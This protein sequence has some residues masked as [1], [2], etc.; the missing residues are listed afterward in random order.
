MVPILRKTCKCIIEP[1][2]LR[3]MKSSPLLP[4]QRTSRAAAMHEASGGGI[5][6]RFIRKLDCKNI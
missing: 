6:E 3:G 4:A 5:D 2:T 1:C